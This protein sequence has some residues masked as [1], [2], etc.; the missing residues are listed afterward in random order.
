MRALVLHRRRQI[1]AASLLFVV[2]WH[3]AHRFSPAMRCC[4]CVLVGALVHSVAG[5]YLPGVAPIEYHEGAKVDLKVNKLTSTKTQLPYEWYSLPFC[6]PE[7]V[8]HQAENLGEVMRGDRIENSAYDIRMNTEESC[9]VR[10]APCLSALSSLAY[11][12]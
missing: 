3:F 5:F 6:K 7:E 12:L 9:K 11:R 8:F 10:C 4:S 1:A 2:R